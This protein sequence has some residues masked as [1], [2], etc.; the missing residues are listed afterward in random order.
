MEGK[1]FLTVAQK[2][3]QTRT[4]AAIRSACSRT[5]YAVFNTGIKLL[6]DLGFTLPRDAS[7]HEQLYQRLNNAGIPDIKD[8]AARL[9]DLRIRR[10][11]ADYDMANRDFQSHT[12]CEFDIARTKL[13]IA[14]LESYY[15]QP[16]RNQL[17]DGIR[18]YERK[19]NPNP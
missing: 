3:V 4:E 6:S 11:H 9:K 12:K 17:K 18:E 10:V 13:I 15:Q 7:V 19:I 2:L 14:Q 16:L 1:E 8:V 5:Y